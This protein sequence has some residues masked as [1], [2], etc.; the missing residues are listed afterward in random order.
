M[1][2]SR[3]GEDPI[4]RVLLRRRRH[5]RPRLRTIL[6]CPRCKA[7]FH[8]SVDR[9]GGISL[10]CGSCSGEGEWP[11]PTCCA[12]RR[13]PVLNRPVVQRWGER[14]ADLDRFAGGFD[15]G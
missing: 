2:L 1:R 5:V 7:L 9:S 12:A 15:S 6:K 11:P 3:L 13:P 8:A 4:I 10:M 14:A